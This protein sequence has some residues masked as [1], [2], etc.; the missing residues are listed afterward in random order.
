MGKK[1]FHIQNPP[2]A[3]YRHVIHRVSPYC[4]L[5]QLA[6]VNLIIY[7]LLGG[8]TQVASGERL[9]LEFMS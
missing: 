1:G 4:L 3:L 2:D 5:C 6:L 8:L 9:K 7:E